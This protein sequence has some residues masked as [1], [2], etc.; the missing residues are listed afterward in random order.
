[1]ALTE[2]KGQETGTQKVVIERGPV[3]V[4]EGPER[5]ISGGQGYEAAIE[6]VEHGLMGGLG[7]HVQ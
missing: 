7:A 4:V 6:G 1:M 3:R 2:L 5:H